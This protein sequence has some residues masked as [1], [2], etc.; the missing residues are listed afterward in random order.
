MK[1]ASFE[2]FDMKDKD[3]KEQ[4]PSQPLRPL[5]LPSGAVR[6]ADVLPPPLPRPEISSAE[7]AAREAAGGVL[8]FSREIAPDDEEDEETEDTG[9]ARP[10]SAQPS[11]PIPTPRPKAEDVF[12]YPEAA[13]E[14]AETS[15]ETP[16]EAWDYANEQSAKPLESSAR[17]VISEILPEPPLHPYTPEPLPPI[18]G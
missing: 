8:L 6:G 5:H 2:G 1:V 16:A 3:E 4:A 11:R 9:S 15:A 13:G 7:K 12:V 14:P 10:S 18:A 17:P